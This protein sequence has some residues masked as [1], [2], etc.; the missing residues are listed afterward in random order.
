M[1]KQR[2]TEMWQDMTLWVVVATITYLIY[3][4]TF[5]GPYPV[6]HNPNAAAWRHGL[7]ADTLPVVV[8]PIVVTVRH[9]RTPGYLRTL[10]APLLGYVLVAGVRSACFI[11][12]A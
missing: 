5:D 10:L 7:L 4:S 2:R 11:V 6:C 3:S 12:G 8:L 1:D 9:W